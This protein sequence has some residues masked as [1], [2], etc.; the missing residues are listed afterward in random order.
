MIYNYGVAL[1]KG[2]LAFGV[3][4][5]HYGRGG[6]FNVI[7][8]IAV[9]CFMMLSFMFLG[10][11]LIKFSVGDCIV[12]IKKLCLPYLIWPLVY[13]Y[14]YSFFYT[15]F[16]V[17]LLG[18]DWQSALFYQLIL[19][20]SII[21]PFWFHWC[22]IVLTILTYVLSVRNKHIAL[23]LLCILS[24]LAFFCQYSGINWDIF[25]HFRYEIKYPLGRFLEM[26]PYCFAG[27]FI[28]NYMEDILQKLR[29]SFY[30]R[31]IVA[32]IACIAFVVFYLL[33]DNFLGDN[34]GYAGIQLFF[35]SLSA[36]ICAWFIP[37]DHLFKNRCSKYFIKYTLGIY[38]IH[39]LVGNVFIRIF[40]VE[41]SLLRCIIIYILSYLS[42]LI[43]DRFKCG[44]IKK[45]IE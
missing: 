29:N 22:L 43:L 17:N 31:I 41:N 1:L 9:P 6:V 45:L 42:C 27:L 24:I 20:H 18:L 14:L 3:V 40:D 33:P 34:F 8:P 11:H 10:K 7:T 26:V 38:C 16:D 23:C 19:G 30:L 37:I 35:K 15:V 13:I 25:N 36:V 2:I 28:G 44:F 12:R 5:A 21:P 4:G 39:M 32:G